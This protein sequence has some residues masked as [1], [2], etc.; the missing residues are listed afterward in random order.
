MT[1]DRQSREA[2]SQ[3]ES[4]VGRISRKLQ[5]IDVRSPPEAVAGLVV[6]AEILLT[7][8]PPLVS[9]R[10]R[11]P[12]RILEHIE[13]CASVFEVCEEITAASSIADLG[14]GNG[15]PGI[16]VALL[17]RN[18][19]LAPPTNESPP[20]VSLIERSRRRAAFLRR[21]CLE[22][23]APAE[24]LVPE[25]DAPLIPRRRFSVVLARA[26]APLPAVPS[27]VATYLAPE[28]TAVVWAGNPDRDTRAECAGA[29]R[30]VGLVGK[31]TKPVKL[32]SRGD[33]LSMSFETKSER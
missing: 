2:L 9:R 32:R 30:S 4:G 11:S 21:V 26:L 20:R 1:K 23:G 6:F 7:A 19:A 5:E 16:V 13:D 10:D 29:C 33:L 8:R 31:W 3:I 22:V 15:L 27:L 14:S 18:R 28:G 17:L 24:V 12:R 25:G